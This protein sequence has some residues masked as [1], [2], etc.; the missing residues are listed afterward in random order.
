VISPTWS[1]IQCG[2]GVSVH[3]SYYILLTWPHTQTKKKSTSVSG[4]VSFKQI[5]LKIH[6]C[7]HTEGQPTSM[8]FQFVVSWLLIFIFNF[9]CW[10]LE[11]YVATQ[12]V[13]YC[14]PIWN[15]KPG[16]YFSCIFRKILLAIKNKI[17]H[18]PANILSPVDG[19]SMQ[20][21][22]SVIK[23]S[24]NN[25]FNFSKIYLIAQK[26]TQQTTLT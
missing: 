19:C 4:Q 26:T 21:L 25:K 18:W 5:N 10:R 1:N 12:F 11:I 8:G 7:K 23:V 13:G 3:G 2:F 15:W 6:N 24:H 16:N 22:K 20:L 14:R 9:I 17:L